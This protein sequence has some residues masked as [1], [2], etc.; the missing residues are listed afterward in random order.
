[1]SDANI[2]ITYDPAHKEKAI[3]EVISMMKNVKETPK[4]YES[5]VQGVLLTKIMNDPSAVIKKICSC[6]R[7]TPAEYY[8]TK[9]WVPIERWCSSDIDELGKVMSE[10]S[11]RIDAKHK[12]KM[13]ISK[14]AYER[15]TVID[16]IMQLTERINNTNVDLKNPDMIVKIEI[17]GRKAGVSLLK[18]GNI[19]DMSCLGL[20][21]N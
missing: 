13:E 18:K 7:K 3:E 8:V 10:F 11:K 16:M 2:L 19:M 20:Q 6:C 17:M 1:M 4:F 21:N 9:K 5:G 15:H 12:W 14:R